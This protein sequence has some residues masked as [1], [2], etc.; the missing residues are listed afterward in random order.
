M[1]PKPSPRVAARAQR[2]PEFA[3]SRLPEEGV[4]ELRAE[5]DE[6][7]VWFYQAFSDAI[8][9][10]AVANRRFGGPQFN[11]SRMTWIKPSFGWVLYRSGYAGKH[12][13]E[14]LLKVKV[15]HDVVAEILA[16]CACK[17]G[18][19][20]T[21]GRVQWDPERDM[22][23]G[24]DPGKRNKEP[25]K[26][27]ATRSIQIGISKKLSELYVASAVAIEDVTDLARRVG[28]AHSSDN[29]KEAMDALLGELPDE[30]PYV[31]QLGAQELARLCLV[32]EGTE[33]AEP[34]FPTAG[35]RRRAAEA[36]ADAG[37]GPSA[38]APSEEE[39]EGAYRER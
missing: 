11:P 12:N 9:D 6:E 16:Q 24:D 13:Q 3:Q 31:P 25:R 37:P 5:F 14:R 23:S 34:S 18:G 33:V 4:H 1:A 7:G 32:P 17:R 28:E 26:M 19:G 27:L 20:G 38:G 30:R 8:A 10:Y 22:H 29:T 35:C 21:T 2:D 36:E 15:P 39:E